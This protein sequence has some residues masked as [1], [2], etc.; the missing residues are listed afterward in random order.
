MNSSA[1]TKSVRARLE[2]RLAGDYASNG[3]LACSGDAP[4]AEIAGLMAR[5]NV[6]AIVVV[7]DR[8]A[9]PPIVS[10]QD[11]IGAIASGHFDEMTASDVAGTEA[12]SIFHDEDLARAAQLL[13]EHRVSHLVVRNARREPVGIVSS[14]E[15]AE[16]ASG[17]G[18]PPRDRA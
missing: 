8:A 16:A 17:L 5:N 2:D 7:D 14:L 12:V 13:A 15:L 3:I 11:L 6:H 4:L 1:H 10:D 18:R 9:E